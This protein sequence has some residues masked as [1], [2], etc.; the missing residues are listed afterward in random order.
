[1]TREVER[2]VELNMTRSPATDGDPLAKALRVSMF[3][4]LI[5]NWDELRGTPSEVVKKFLIDLKAESK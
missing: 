4:S 2:S 3:A 1:M 5:L